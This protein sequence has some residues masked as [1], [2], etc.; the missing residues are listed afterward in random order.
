MA[1][2][3]LSGFDQSSV[4]FGGKDRLKCERVNVLLLALTVWINDCWMNEERSGERGLG[5]GGK[6]C[7]VAAFI[8]FSIF[9]FVGS[10]GGGERTGMDGYRLTYSTWDGWDLGK[11][12]SAHLAD[13]SR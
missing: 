2:S 9:R 7:S 13:S 3:S 4:P 6:Y 12:C 8:V 11:V 10:A 1:G 5:M